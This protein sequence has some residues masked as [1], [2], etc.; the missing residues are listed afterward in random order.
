ME[1]ENAMDQTFCMT[2]GYRLAGFGR[3]P[4]EHRNAER[5]PYPGHTGHV[6]CELQ[7]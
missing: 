7:D 5:Q 6:M 2:E 1:S 3:Y 4:P